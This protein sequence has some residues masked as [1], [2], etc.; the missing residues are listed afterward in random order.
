MDP[1]YPYQERT[2]AKALRLGGRMA[3][4]N[5]VGTGK[6]RC[7]IEIAKRLGVQ[8]VL[9]VSPLNI[10]PVWKSQQEQWWPE[11]QT[12]DATLGKIVERAKRVET[13]ASPEIPTIVTVGYESFWREPLA[14][15]ILA[16][17]PELV[18]YDEGHRIKGRTSKQAK[19]AHT[20]RDRVRYALVV[21]GT[22]AANGPQDYFSEY[23]AVRA[24]VFGDRW[25]DFEDDYI[26]VT[27][28]H[29]FPLI[30]GYKNQT[31]FE[32]RLHATSTRVTKAE[33]IELPEEVDVVIPVVLTS[34][35]R[36]AYTML[37]RRAM[38]EVEGLNGETGTALSRIVLTNVLRLMQI[39]S[40]F[41]RV[42][43]D[44]EIDIGTEKLDATK[45]LITD[46]MPR[47]VVVFAHF[48]R[49]VHRLVEMCAKIA[50][51]YELS[52]RIPQAKR[53]ANVEQWKAADKGII[54][55]QSQVGSQGID[56]T[57]SDVAIFYS[58]DFDYM[59][60]Y[61]SR[62]R[63]HRIGQKK[64]VTYYSIVAKGTVDEKV[65]RALTKKET[66]AAALLDDSAAREILT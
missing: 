29:G 13:I 31:E 4:F 34:K 24:D 53:R 51:T 30:L 62:G 26:R 17:K 46:L 9:V 23:K 66:Q 18:I 21:T 1:L 59:H 2:I 65:H 57:A 25:Q 37:R 58:V 7:S 3:I 48:T 60:W 5:D 38:A 45:E 33:A 20:L 50:P 39:T 42:T 54:V 44:R 63:V 56:L 27:R 40:G 36:D 16:W 19:F 11:A 6:T 32:R 43:D 15:T 61:Q 49:D 22:P 14:K 12:V 55:C 52:G 8:R 10:A 41:V 64:K 47:H 35:T 28:A